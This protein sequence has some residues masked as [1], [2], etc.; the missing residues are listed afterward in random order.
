M[1][2]TDN[3]DRVGRYTLAEARQIVG[4]ANRFSRQGVNEIAL[5]VELVW[6]WGRG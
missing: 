6:G 1:G 4:D 3:S 2:Y 5:P